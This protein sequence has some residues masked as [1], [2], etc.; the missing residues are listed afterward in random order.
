MQLDWV[1][2]IGFKA[3]VDRRAILFYYI[4]CV[5]FA[6]CLFQT[7]NVWI[8]FEA[9]IKCYLVIKIYET[10]FKACYKSVPC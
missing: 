4:C 8:S 3:V 5:Q 6:T 9:L 2:S 1:E 10:A 7:C